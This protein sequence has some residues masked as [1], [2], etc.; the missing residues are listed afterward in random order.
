M[1]DMIPILRVGD[2]IPE[3][4]LP[5]HT[6][7]IQSFASLWRKQ[8]TAFVF[9]RHF[10]CPHCRAQAVTL[11]QDKQQFEKVNVAVVL[12]G[13]GTPAQAQEFRQEFQLPFLVLVDITKVSY[14]EF[15]L[16]H[17]RMLKELA[18]TATIHYT[19]NMLKF[20]MN[21]LP[22]G[23]D[24]RQLGGVFIADHDGTLL[25]TFRSESAREYPSTQE[26]VS[27]L[28]STDISASR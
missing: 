12:I 24:M 19:R 18:P 2:A 28:T 8:R 4:L 5:D 1:A 23:Q 22:K 17:M 16:V 27:A 14:Y 3:V 20:G 10:G 25:Y 15:G 13:L 6:G 9:L 26:M 21:A 11:R 7:E